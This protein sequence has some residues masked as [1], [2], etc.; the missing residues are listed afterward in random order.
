M[1]MS[2]RI[3]KDHKKSMASQKKNEIVLEKQQKAIH[4]LIK[5]DE[6]RIRRESAINMFIQAK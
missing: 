2:K 1:E 5:W 6:Y 3:Q 4:N